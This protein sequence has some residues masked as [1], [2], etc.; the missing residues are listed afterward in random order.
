[1]LWST[2]EHLVNAFLFGTLG[3]YFLLPQASASGLPVPLAIGGAALAISY[4]T[5]FIS[6]KLPINY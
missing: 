4:A 2:K 1:M 6:D 3:A 5:D